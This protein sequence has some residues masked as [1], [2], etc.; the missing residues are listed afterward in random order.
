[1]LWASMKGKWKARVQVHCSYLFEIELV[2]LLHLRAA[3]YFITHWDNLVC[4]LILWSH[5]CHHLCVWIL[6]VLRL[7][8]CDG[9]VYYIVIV[10]LF[11]SIDNILKFNCVFFSYLVLYQAPHH[12]ATCVVL[13]L[14]SK[15]SIHFTLVERN[16]LGK[17]IVTKVDA[18]IASNDTLNQIVNNTK[19]LACI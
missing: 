1:M 14:E 6:F 16:F 15:N 4:N 17:S 19:T 8:I 7:P 10:S 18:Y 13:A 12:K 3:W 5:K 2:Y 11:S 9:R